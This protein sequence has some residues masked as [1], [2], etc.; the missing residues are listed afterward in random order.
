MKLQVI[1]SCLPMYRYSKEADNGVPQL[2][3]ISTF[4]YLTE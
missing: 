2:K 3:V 4:N 1:E